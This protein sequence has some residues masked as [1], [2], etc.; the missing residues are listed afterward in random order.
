[1][2]DRA[3]DRPTRV[4]GPLPAAPRV[5]PM[6]DETMSDEQKP[7]LYMVTVEFEGA[8]ARDEPR[9]R[10]GST[11][12][13]TTTSGQDM[14]GDAGHASTPARSQGVAAAAD[15]RDALPWLAADVEDSRGHACAE[16][17][18]R[19]RCADDNRG[20]RARHTEARED[21]AAGIAGWPGRGA[22][23]PRS[24]SARRA[25]GGRSRMTPA[26]TAGGHGEVSRIV[27]AGRDADQIP[28]WTVTHGGQRTSWQKWRRAGAAHCY[29]W[30]CPRSP[31]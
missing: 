18:P 25:G 7:R 15:M 16:G 29:G 27:D 1:M 5:A 2:T 20:R 28:T 17:C 21:D 11:R 3:G 22:R 31:G 30:T 12:R 14:R 19:R 9:G 24:A 8:R 13:T 4:R 23:R 6:E 10:R 26:P